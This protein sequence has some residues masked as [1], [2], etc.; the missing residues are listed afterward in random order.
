[1]DRPDEQP[2]THET[3]EDCFTYQSPDTK[4]R[5]AFDMLR[6]QLVTA[7]RA[8]LDYCPDSAD[9]DRALEA[10]RASRMWANSAI[11]HR[12]RF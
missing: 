7:G 10:L 1:M 3:I 12:G 4:Q 5:A 11:A 2:V 8:I 9:R 6:K